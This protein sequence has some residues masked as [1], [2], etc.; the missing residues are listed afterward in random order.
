MKKQTLE[1]VQHQKRIFCGINSIRSLCELLKVDQRKLELLAQQPQ[2][3]TFSIPKKNGG[4]RQIEVPDKTHKMILGRLNTYL[5]SVY[6]FE[7]SNASYGFILGV[8]NDDDR[9]NVVANARK[10][11]SLIHI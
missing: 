10:H 6:F 11:L 8:R 1:R 3:K 4:E 9:R 2:Y 7:K 5:Q